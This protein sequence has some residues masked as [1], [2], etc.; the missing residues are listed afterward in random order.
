MNHRREPEDQDH[1]G[2]APDVGR[3]SEDARQAGNRAF[4]P[5]PSGPQWPGREPSAA[6]LHG[7]PSTDTEARTPL[8]VGTSTTRRA[9]KIARREGEA[10]RRTKGLRGRS[11]RPAGTS[12]PDH[13]TGVGPQKTIDEESPHLP[14]GDQ[15]G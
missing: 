11:G 3:G 12:E 15:A 13:D 8:G 5:P 4:G 2:T 7:V 9:E 10:G 6:E 1:H 14:T